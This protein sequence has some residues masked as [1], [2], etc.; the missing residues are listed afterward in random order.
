MC[1]TVLLMVVFSQLLGR[2][3]V[4]CLTYAKHTGCETRPFQLFKMFPVG[5][6]C[7]QF[8]YCVFFMFWQHLT[9]WRVWPFKI[10]GVKYHLTVMR[11]WQ[12]I[13]AMLRLLVCARLCWRGVVV[14]A[15][16]PC[17]TLWS[18]SKLVRICKIYGE[19]FDNLIYDTRTL[20]VHRTSS[21]FGDTTFAGA[22]TRVWNSLPSD[23][24]KAEL[25]Y[26][27]FRRSLKTF[28]FGQSDHGAL[29]TF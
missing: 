4:P 25:S 13:N 19:K 24:R 6:V 15:D 2:Y 1:R 29:R 20:T 26:S 16:Y 7:C 9:W 5:V 17:C 10:H 27:R 22:A 23:L 12:R 8:H 18:W 21:C 11:C 14:V 28:L 3:H